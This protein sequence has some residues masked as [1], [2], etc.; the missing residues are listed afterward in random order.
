LG[1][2]LGMDV[3]IVSEVIV[4]ECVILGMWMEDLEI[5]VVVE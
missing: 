1:V 3:A 5:V 2:E 4:V